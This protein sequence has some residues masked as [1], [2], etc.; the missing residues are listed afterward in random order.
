MKTS[1][2]PIVCAL[3]VNPEGSALLLRRHPGK[4]GG[5]KWGLP[6][7]KLEQGESPVEAIKREIYEETGIELRNPR[8]IAT[9]KIVMPHGTVSM[10]TFRQDLA[11]TPEIKTNPGEHIDSLWVHPSEILTTADLLFGVP[12]LMRD[13]GLIDG[14]VEDMTLGDG[15]SVT[16]LKTG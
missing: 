1:I 4:Q 7:G 2:L 13:Y 14:S 9:H 16:L 12:T 10:I 15:A 8:E 6:G 5:D 3:I 11:D